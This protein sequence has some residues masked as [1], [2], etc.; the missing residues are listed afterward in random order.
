MSFCSATPPRMLPNRHS[1]RPHTSVFR[2]PSRPSPFPHRDAS[3]TASPAPPRRDSYPSFLSPF[4]AGRRRCRRITPILVTSSH[5]RFTLLYLSARPRPRCYTIAVAVATSSL[6]SVHLSSL[7][8]FRS[9]APSPAILVS[10]PCSCVPYVSVSSVLGEVLAKP[11]APSVHSVR[12]DFSF[13]QRSYGRRSGDAGAVPFST[14]S[15][16]PSP[17]DSPLLVSSP[18]AIVSPSSTRGRVDI[19]RVR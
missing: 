17:L 12:G 4:L 5:P 15:I 2:L 9:A 10:F 8:V 14:S 6:L 7:F 19:L 3:A 16:S 13:A 1:P 18:P 11:T